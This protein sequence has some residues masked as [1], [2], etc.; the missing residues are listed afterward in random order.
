MSKVN[1]I[2]KLA[3]LLKCEVG[4]ILFIVFM[5]ALCTSWLWFP[6]LLASLTYGDWTCAYKECVIIK[7]MGDEK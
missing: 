5:I 6:P 1:T 2:N 7:D 4:Y 3:K